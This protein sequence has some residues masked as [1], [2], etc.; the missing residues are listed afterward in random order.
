MG[1][2][3]ADS[4]VRVTRAEVIAMN[5]EE[6]FLDFECPYCNDPVSFPVADARQ[7]REC[8]L[9]SETLVVPDKAGAAGHKFPIPITTTRLILRRLRMADWKDL[10]ELMSD[11]KLLQ[12]YEGRTMEEAEILHWLESD[13]TVRWTTPGQ[14]FYLGIEAQEG[15]K[16]IGYLKL[17]FADTMHRQAWVYVVMNP[18]YQRQ[19]VAMEALAAV[20]D[21][22]LGEI[23][24]HRIMVWH[25]SRD[26]AARGLCE[27]LG[28]RREGESL[29]DRQLNGEW[30][31][32]VYYALLGEERR[33]SAHD[34]A[35]GG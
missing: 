27:K 6:S 3:A 12:Y 31:N 29:K 35:Q 28:L 22:A 4:G 21:F 30:I 23:A 14:P 8:P 20:R 32:S 19:G 10:L 16:L 34:P 15:G 2:A 17:E 11:E 7:A 13:S 24:M 26:L 5:P 1:S 9:C 18:A 25:D 33:I